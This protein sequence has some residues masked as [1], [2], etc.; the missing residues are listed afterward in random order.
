[1][2]R[3][4]LLFKSGRC[5]AVYFLTRSQR[6]ISDCA[7]CERETLSPSMARCTSGIMLCSAWFSSAL[8]AQPHSK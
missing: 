5:E 8:S 6:Q 4:L 7:R 1:M 3:S 2:T